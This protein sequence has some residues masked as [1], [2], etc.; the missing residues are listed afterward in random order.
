MDPGLFYFGGFHLPAYFTMLATGFSVAVF[1]AW[2]WAKK[3]GI[4]PGKM[5]DF[6]ILMAIFGIVG[7][8]ILHIFADG[9]FYDYINVCIAPE[10]VDWHVDKKECAALKGVF[11][12]A[13]KVCHPAG[14][15]C[16]AWISGNGFA[17]YGGFIA[18]AVFAIWFIRRHRWPPGKICDMA[19]W[20]IML[21]LSFGRMGCF[22]AGCCFGAVTDSPLGVSFPPAS[23]ASRHQWMEGMLPSYR[24]ES[25]PVHPTQLYESLGALAISAAAYFLVRPNKRFDGQ[26]FVFSMCAYAVVR[27]LLEFIRR[28]ERGSIIGLS[29][30]QLIAICVIAVSLY[31]FSWFKKKSLTSI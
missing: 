2:R 5:I 25:V 13:E 18:A 16:L 26:V 17:F 30:S 28:D 21:G 10:K 24:M 15:N 31:L 11:D 9:H 7:A 19:G 27:F 20:T 12:S 29:T 22:L 14:K 1:L 23:P 3:V 8:K 4:D 6:G